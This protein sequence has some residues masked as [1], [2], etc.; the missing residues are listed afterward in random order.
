MNTRGMKDKRTLTKAR[1]A[2]LSVLLGAALLF[3]GCFAG[4]LD[5]GPPPARLALIPALPPP[6]PGQAIDK[7]LSV[8][9]PVCGGELDNDRI[10]TVFADREVRYLADTRWTSSVPVLLRTTMIEALE[11]VGG[12]RGVGDELAGL[13]A[14]A[15]LLTDLRK[16]AL[17]YETE[18]GAPVAVFEAGFRLLNLR[19]GKV[20]ASLTVSEKAGAAGEERTAL[21]SAMEAALQRGL[22]RLAPWVVEEMHKLK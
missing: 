13:A 18:G 21:A 22:A 19:N 20:M 6:L 5:P 8:A 9:L 15:R 7:Q 3:S 10:A 1:L 14:D 17:Y 2:A 16:F 11:A 4:V 12:L